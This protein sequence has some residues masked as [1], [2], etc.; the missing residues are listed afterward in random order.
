MGEVMNASCP[1]CGAPLKYDGAK[2]K[3]GCDSCG[4]QFDVDLM[5]QVDDAIAQG[6]A[7]S[8]MEW[9]QN[10]TEWSAQEQAQMK[11][12]NCPSCGA[13]IITDETTVAT[14]CVYCGNPSILPGKLDS[15]TRPEKV[16]PFVKEK[17]DAQAAFKELIKGKKLLPD[18]FLKHN[19]IED[20]TGVYVPFWTFDCQAQAKMVY[21]A[22]KVTHHTQGDY[23]V[24]TTTHYMA[25][26][27][28]SI[29]FDKIPVDGST[30]FDDTLM[31][32]IEPYRYDDLKDFTSAY[33][34]GYQA[35]IHDVSMSV[36]KL[37]ADERV[38]ESVEREFADTV[39]GYTSVHVQ[40]ENINLQDG[41]AENVL[42]PVWMLNAR[43]KDKVYAFAMNGQTGKFI[44]DLPI[45]KAKRWKWAGMYF[46]AAFIALYGLTY[47]LCAMGVM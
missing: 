37:R 33:L 11:A 29:G 21:R 10:E 1:C 14:Q 41:R 47:V 28:G 24:T 3:L 16:I 15:A 39:R 46:G 22:E 25:L 31:E 45:D 44:G 9:T 18:G 6:K 5:Q 23:D 34:P 26:R 42:L 4:N 8:V 12:Y 2:A 30:K 43:W 7:E 13:E 40:S 20:I 35:E 36:A 17:A 38:T 27:D 32:A 19:R